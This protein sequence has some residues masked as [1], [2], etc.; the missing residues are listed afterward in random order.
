MDG[1][2]VP[3]NRVV[4]IVHPIEVA[5]EVII[6]KRNV[7]NFKKQCQQMDYGYLETLGYIRFLVTNGIAFAGNDN[8]RKRRTR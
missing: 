3:P 5:L 1:T 4:H 7:N 2:S 6:G 8:K